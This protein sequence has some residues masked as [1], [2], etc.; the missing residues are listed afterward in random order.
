[1]PLSRLQIETAAD[2]IANDALSWIPATADD[3]KASGTRLHTPWIFE[4]DGG[5]PKNGATKNTPAN[6]EGKQGD[7]VSWKNAIDRLGNAGNLPPVFPA[8]LKVNFYRAPEGDGITLQMRYEFSG[9]FYERIV[10]SG[11]ATWLG[12]D[13][14]EVPE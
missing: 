4:S 14:E 10:V 1:M 12:H 5:H 9:K 6:L 3:F 7:Q 11:P 13:W 8:D 2:I